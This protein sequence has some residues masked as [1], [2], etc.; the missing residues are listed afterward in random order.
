MK[1]KIRK[2]DKMINIFTTFE[3]GQCNKIVNDFHLITE[4]QSD[5][6]F[7]LHNWGLR[8]V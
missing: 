8:K 1:H 4:V 5:R 3:R 7:L 6:V 2:L